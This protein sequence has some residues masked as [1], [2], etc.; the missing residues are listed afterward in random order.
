MGSCDVCVCVYISYTV[1]ATHVRNSELESIQRSQTVS[2]HQYDIR[3][4]D[5][6]SDIKNSN[7]KHLLRTYYISLTVLGN[8]MHIIL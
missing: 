7:S 3:I 8:F 4:S 2:I 5:N 1:E 6:G